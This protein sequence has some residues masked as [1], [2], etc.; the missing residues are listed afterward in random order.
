MHCVLNDRDPSV[1]RC[2][3]GSPSS[4]TK[5]RIV[6]RKVPPWWSVRE[7]APARTV[8]QAAYK[9][10]FLIHTSRPSFGAIDDERRVCARAPFPRKGTTTRAGF[11]THA[12]LACTRAR[13]RTGRGTTVGAPQDDQE[14]SLQNLR[15][16][17]RESSA[18]AQ[19]RADERPSQTTG[20]ELRHSS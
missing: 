4:R 8:I 13:A 11:L 1:F 6:A 9:Y 20:A 18:E 3:R 12:F 19:L 7:R 16:V 15:A 10:I 17:G 5:R 14:R 2:A